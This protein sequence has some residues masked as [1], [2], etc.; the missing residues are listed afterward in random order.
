MHSYLADAHFDGING[1]RDLSRMTVAIQGFGNVGYHAAKFLSEDDKAKIICVIEHDGAIYDPAGI[2]IEALKQHQ[3][4]SGS[5]K[6][7]TGGSVSITQDE[8]LWVACDILVPAAMENAITMAKV[9]EVRAKLIVEAANGPIRFD[10]DQILRSRGITILPD[11]FVNAGGVA[12]S[13]FEWIKNLTHIPFGLMERRRQERRGM[14]LTHAMEEIS[15]KQLSPDLRQELI[16]SGNE[17]D[18]VR[19]GLEDV[20]RNAYE[21]MSTALSQNPE[22]KDFRTAAYVC[23]IQSIEAAYD[24]IGI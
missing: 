16:G 19:S 23:S 8:G 11:L 1:N 20:M 4:T 5:I 3:I 17:I 2:D 18:L 7:F 15:G 12:V 22:L 21:R 14:T 24:A 6:D 9:D 13:Y 10:A